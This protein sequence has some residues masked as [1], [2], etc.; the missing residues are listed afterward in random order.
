M[1][2][3]SNHVVSV[4]VDAALAAGADPRRIARLLGV[5]HTQ[6]LDRAVRVPTADVT[7]LWA[8]LYE[9][10]GTEAG[11]LAAEH[12]EHG[13]LYVWDYL[14]STA[15]TL[16][17]GLRE[18]ARYN[19][20]ICDPRVGLEVVEDGSLL[21][22][23][24]FDLPH[25][26]P[27]DRLN[28]EFA[29]VVT[30]RRARAGFGAS[31]I[32]VRVDFSHPA[33]RDRRYLERAFGAGNIHFDQSRDALKF[34]GTAARPN[35]PFLHAILRRH[36]TE[37][38]A[39]GGPERAWLEVFRDELRTRLSARTGGTMLDEVARALGLSGRTLQRRLAEQGTTWRAELETVRRDLAITLLCE[40]SDSVRSIAVQLGYRDHRVLARAF[41]RWTGSAPA[42]FR[43]AQSN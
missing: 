26:A 17:A 36:A 28:R 12:A 40:R 18:A 22:A 24:Y 35:D 32:P 4:L 21:T 30:A 14:I 1:S 2:T 5:D 16:A 33:P 38:L 6:L 15:P 43:R 10:A 7:R 31:G 3:V 29:M 27:Y 20:T 11:A 37:V 13:R 9:V 42:D 34:L 23:R 8:L 19:S 41:R 39:A 25:R